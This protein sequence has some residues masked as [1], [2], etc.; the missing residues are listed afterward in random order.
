VL[1]E[2]QMMFA[3][4]MLK[5]TPVKAMWRQQIVATEYL[6]MLSGPGQRITSPTSPNNG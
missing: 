6:L 4:T 3:Q 2:Q 5:A 1:F